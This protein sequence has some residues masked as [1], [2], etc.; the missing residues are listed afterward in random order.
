MVFPLKY[1]HDLFTWGVEGNERF[2]L[3]LHL[4]GSL[5]LSRVILGLPSLLFFICFSPWGF[6]RSDLLSPSEHII[7]IFELF[8]REFNFQNA[9]R[10]EPSSESF[11]GKVIWYVVN[12]VMDLLKCSKYSVFDSPSSCLTLTGSISSLVRSP[13]QLNSS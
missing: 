6:R 9:S 5:R 1:G 12:Q 13:A 3:L 8:R 4:D 2:E 7:A 11:D 10:G